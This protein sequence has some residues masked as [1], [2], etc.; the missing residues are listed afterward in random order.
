[1]NLDPDCIFCRIIKGDIP[2]AKVYEDDQTLA[3]MDIGPVNPGHVLIIPKRHVGL[4]WEA[5][6]E[7]ARACMDIVLKVARA[8]HEATG[9]PGMNLIQ[10]N[11]ACAGQV[12]EH[13]H[14]HVIPRDPGDGMKFGWRQGKYGE[15]ELETMQRKIVRS[16]T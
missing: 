5:T 16:L 12:V 4:L 15:G 2:A 7:E 11:H 3:F 1:M 8:V 13:C 14:F 9:W 6:A 10:N